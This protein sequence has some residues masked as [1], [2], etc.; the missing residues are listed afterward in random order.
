MHVSYFHFHL[1]DF[2]FGHV[3][4]YILTSYLMY[5]III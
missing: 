5:N 2:D 4:F 1:N 3:L